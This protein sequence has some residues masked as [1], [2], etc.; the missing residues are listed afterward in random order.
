MLD[1]CFL[2]CY[3]FINHRSSLYSMAEQLEKIP[4]KRSARDKANTMIKSLVVLGSLVTPGV[5]G[6][7]KIVAKAG[8]KLIKGGG[9]LVNKITP[10][11][12]RGVKTSGKMP[13][14]FGFDTVAAKLIGPYNINAPKR[15]VVVGT[16]VG[17]KGQQIAKEV[18]SPT[19][20]DAL[21][22]LA[23]MFT[24]VP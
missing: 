15:M 19:F 24:E 14:G 7:S 2:F 10:E 5:S 21:K 22:S 17:T 3:D 18:T 16:K 23:R 13:K 6:K 12:V 4:Q 1:F 8:S 11:M 9:R 20:T